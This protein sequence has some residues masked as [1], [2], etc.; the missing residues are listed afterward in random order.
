MIILTLA[1]LVTALCGLGTLVMIMCDNERAQTLLVGA[2]ELLGLVLI[3]ALAPLFGLAGAA[4][5]A[6]VGKSIGKIMACVFCY[7]S[8]SIDPS[9]LCLLRAPSDKPGQTSG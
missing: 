4:I 5:A 6:L 9:V 1:Q 2:S 8:H 3:F 7:R